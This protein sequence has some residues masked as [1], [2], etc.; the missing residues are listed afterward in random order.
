MVVRSPALGCWRHGPAAMD[1]AQGC[2]QKQLWR[3]ATHLARSRVIRS[4]ASCLS[5][6][7]KD[8]SR[9]FRRVSRSS[10]SAATCRQHLVTFLSRD[11]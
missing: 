5:A 4:W 2:R 1:R 9:A 7:R 3:S 6:A 11:Q 10:P 8:S